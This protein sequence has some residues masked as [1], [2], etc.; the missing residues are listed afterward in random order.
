ML[1]RH[2]AKKQ[3]LTQTE[4]IQGRCVDFD[5]YIGKVKY[6][7]GMEFVTTL[8]GKLIDQMETAVAAKIAREE[9]E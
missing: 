1:C 6:T 3:L 9:A 4:I 7:D 5:D 8:P 2:V